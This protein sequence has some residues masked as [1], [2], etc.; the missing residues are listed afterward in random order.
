MRAKTGGPRSG[1]EVRKATRMIPP[2]AP[3]AA[4]GDRVPAPRQEGQDHPQAYQQIQIR[5]VPRDPSAL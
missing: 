1:G 5:A 2:V 4:S 3:T